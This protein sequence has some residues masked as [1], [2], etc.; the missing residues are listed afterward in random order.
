MMVQTEWPEQIQ[1]VEI[2]RSVYYQQFIEFPMRWH[3][4]RHKSEVFCVTS[5]VRVMPCS[6]S[7]GLPELMQV[8]LVDVEGRNIHT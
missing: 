2:F 1:T 4:Q 7:A 5:K 8:C 6:V 3:I